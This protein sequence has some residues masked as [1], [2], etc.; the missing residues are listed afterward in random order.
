MTTSTLPSTLAQRVRYLRE[1][2]YMTAALLAKRA[3]VPLQ[4][5]EDIEAG[6]ETFLAPAIRMRLARAL[7]VRPMVIREV[8]NEPLNLSMETP[9]LQRESLGL[10]EAMRANPEGAHVCIRCGAPMTVRLFE[11]QDLQENRFT[12]IKANCTQ[13]LFRLTDD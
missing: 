7:H 11:R 6:I 10:L 9:K 12:V 2:R 4:T 8:E 5:I 1:K 3:Q 13:C